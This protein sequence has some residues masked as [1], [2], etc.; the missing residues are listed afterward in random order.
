[1]NKPH[2]PATAAVLI[3]ALVILGATP[4]RAGV[5]WDGSADP[6][7]AGF[8]IEEPQAWTLGNID[9][10][11]NAGGVSAGFVTS[12]MKSRII[13]A[14][15]APEFVRANGYYWEAR[16]RTIT[17]NGHEQGLGILLRD[18]GGDGHGVYLYPD[19]IRWYDGAFANPS[20]FAA[21]TD[22]PIHS[23]GYVTIRL[24]V[25]AGD[26]FATLILNGE[27][28]GTK[29]HNMSSNSAAFLRFG[30][31]SA[32]ADAEADLDYITVNQPIPEPS[33]APLL[34]LGG[35]VLLARRDR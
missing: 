32:V 18:D 26:D 4:A 20:T 7:G 25:E 2:S 15:P 16:V 33:I 11:A 3:Y 5:S 9:Q 34:G 17:H 28:V 22:Y 12:D 23:S 14:D 21:D 27:N 13:V 19:E 30:D 1:M 24:E 10:D 31:Y 6:T 35:L 8:E 29:L